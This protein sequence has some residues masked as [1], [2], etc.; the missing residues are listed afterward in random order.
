MFLKAF[1]A[2]VSH[3]LHQGVTWS[4]VFIPRFAW[5]QNVGQMC[6]P[7]HTVGRMQFTVS[8]RTNALRFLLLGGGY[9]QSPAMYAFPWGNSQQSS[10]LAS[11][12]AKEKKKSMQERESASKTN[13]HYLTWCNHGSDIQSPLPHSVYWKEITSHPHR[14]GG[15][16]SWHEYQEAEII[17]GH[18]RICPLR[19]PLYNWTIIYLT[20]F[21]LMDL[22]VVSSIFASINTAINIDIHSAH[23]LGLHMW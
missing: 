8:C 16:Y 13:V 14:R 4:C 15:D 6:F 10:R 1:N 5:G 17:G 9:P 7:A 2:K 3:R 19:Y 11:K 22:L 20:S 23:V 21:L 18:F 12:Y